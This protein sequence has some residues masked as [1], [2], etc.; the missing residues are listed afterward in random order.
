MTRLARRCEVPRDIRYA[1]V[2]RL[3][4]FSCTYISFFLM[5]NIYIYT[6][7]YMYSLTYVL[8]ST[9]VFGE[10]S[11]SYVKKLSVR[12]ACLRTQGSVPASDAA[13][14]A[15]IISDGRISLLVRDF[16][17][18]HPFCPSLSIL[19]CS[20]LHLTNQSMISRN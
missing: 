2:P 5:Y 19:R 17:N 6:Y 15:M 12:K 8:I 4:Y 11:P 10:F 20:N 14:G 9:M 7:I 16:Q 3:V 13:T 1:N 18:F